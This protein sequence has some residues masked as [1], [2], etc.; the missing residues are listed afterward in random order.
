MTSQ[1]QASNYAK[2]MAMAGGFGAMPLLPRGMVFTT[3]K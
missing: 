1:S 3:A 2:K